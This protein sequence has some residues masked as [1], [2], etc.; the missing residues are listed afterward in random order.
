M[1]NNMDNY[2]NKEF[3]KNLSPFLFNKGRLKNAKEEV[4][5]LLGLLNI[6]M[7][8]KILDM[9]CGTGRH[10]IELAK[11]GYEVT[12]VDFT[13][14]YIETGKTKSEENGL[15]IE[16][17]VDDM[18]EFVREDYFH[19][20]INCF[21]SFGFFENIDEDL[22]SLK[23]IHNSLKPGGKL[24]ME[25][26][27]KEILPTIY[28][29]K[30]WYEEENVL[31]LED[32]QIIDNWK[33]IDMNW[34]IINNNKRYDYSIKMRLYS[35]AELENILKMAGFK[36]I[37]FFGNFYGDEYDTEAERLIVVAQK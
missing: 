5:M 18:R 37:D 31:Y 24:L 3:W 32:T 21:T 1:R 12:G 8:G 30:R 11:K 4:D 14:Y 20:A 19:G 17:I 26:M 15:E 22:Q 36:N 10:S 13:N 35:A 23:N 9:C 7:N 25:M 33:F 34:I 27:G 28:Q 29:D 6:E 16:F 2:N